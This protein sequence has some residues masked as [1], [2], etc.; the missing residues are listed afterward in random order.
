VSVTDT[1]RAPGSAAISSSES[2]LPDTTCPPAV[3]TSYPW[4]YAVFGTSNWEIAFG[5]KLPCPS[6][7]SV[8][9]DAV[10]ACDRVLYP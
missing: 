5:P 3:V 7:R 9:Y 6:A 1:V 10:N 4:G 8:E 2:P